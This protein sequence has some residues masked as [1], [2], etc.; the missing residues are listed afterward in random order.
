M[1]PEEIKALQDKVDG[2]PPLKKLERRLSDQLHSAEE[3]TGYGI[4]PLTILFIISII[5][6]VISIC[7]RNRN[8]ADV[9]MTVKNAH[10]LLPRQL[11]RLKRRL[12]KLWAEHCQ[13]NGK[14]PGNVNPF[15]SAAV[16]SVK[17]CSAE[18]VIGVI[19]ASS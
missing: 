17:E 1:T 14:E 8:E 13:K 11:M 19:R 15:F 10:T 16:N 18:D 9:V 4:D 6:Q 7:L 2:S 3:Q 12:N 5:L